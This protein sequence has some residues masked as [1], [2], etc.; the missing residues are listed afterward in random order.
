[1]NSRTLVAI[2]LGSNLGDRDAHLTFAVSRLSELLSDVTVSSRYDT[3]PVGVL[4]DQPT[5]LNAVLVGRTTLDAHALLRE[6][7]AIELADGRERPYANAPRT[8]DVDLIL[9]GDLIVADDELVV[10]HARFRERAFVLEPLA[11]IAPDLMD[12]V[13]GL[14]VRELLA[15]LGAPSPTKH[16][17]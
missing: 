11:E 15:R 1:M 8:L 9:Y 2:A 7:Q 10:P 14:T 3:A 5:Y 17:S 4:G 12:P 13:A 16:P 6:L